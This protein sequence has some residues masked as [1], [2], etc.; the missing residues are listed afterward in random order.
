MDVCF[1]FASHA[2][3]NL[4]IACICGGRLGSNRSSIGKDIQGI[5]IRFD[6]L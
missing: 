2:I 4:I 1:S 5:V 3:I 6:L